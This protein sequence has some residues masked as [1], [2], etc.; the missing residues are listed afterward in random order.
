[1]TT[2]IVQTSGAVVDNANSY[3]DVTTSDALATKYGL[4]TWVS[5]AGDKSTALFLAAQN[6]ESIYGS[7]FAGCVT[8]QTQPMSFPRTKFYKNNGLVVLE[9]TIPEELTLAQLKL[10]IQSI[11]GIDLNAP[12]A[13]TGNLSELT[14]KVFEGVERTQKW[15][16]PNYASTN[17]KF[18]IGQILSPILL[19]NN[20]RTIR[21]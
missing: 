14:Q 17:P 5:N 11:S 7:S 13:T 1:M 19:A 9:G 10:A 2:L 4:T 3:L 8:I 16:S 15:F 18:E 12:P 6:L 21:A 20:S